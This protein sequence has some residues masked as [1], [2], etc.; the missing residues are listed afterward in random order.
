[1]ATANAASTVTIMLIFVIDPS[2]GLRS[3]E[4]V[5]RQLGQPG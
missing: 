4:S 3:R 2:D 1:V 5:R